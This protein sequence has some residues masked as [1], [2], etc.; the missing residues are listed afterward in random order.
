MYQD[1]RGCQDMCIN[2]MHPNLANS[3]ETS[4]VKDFLHCYDITEETYQQVN[5]GRRE[6]PTVRATF[7]M[8]LENIDKRIDYC[9]GA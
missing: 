7:L 9:A 5:G 1:S 2:C 8:S 6:I 3:V 4:T